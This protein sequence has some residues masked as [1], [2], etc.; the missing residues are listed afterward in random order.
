MKDI[1]DLKAVLIDLPILKK[2]SSRLPELI[3]AYQ[4]ELN[5]QGW[6]TYK[7]Y[8]DG[9]D[10]KYGVAKNELLEAYDQ[11]LS[12]AAGLYVDFKQLLEQLQ[13]YDE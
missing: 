1:D 7:P 9:I 3:E 6:K 8:I 2:Y 4:Y 13:Q 10:L 5:R 11:L 12:Q